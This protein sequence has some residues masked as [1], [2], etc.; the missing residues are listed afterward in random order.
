MPEQASQNAL[1]VTTSPYQSPF[2]TAIY[3]F[4]LGG[5]NMKDQADQIPVG[6]FALHTNLTHTMDRGVTTRY[7]LS[8]YATGGTKHHSV[9]RLSD[10]LNSTYTR[11][12]G[13][14]QDLR[15]GQSGAVAII[16]SG[17]SGDPLVLLPHRPPLSGAPWMFV[18]DRSR[19][20]KVRVDGLD[21]PIG[22]PAPATIPTLSL[23]TEYFTQ[24]ARVDHVDST[25]ATAWTPNAGYTFP[26]PLVGNAP[27]HTGV[28]TMV[29]DS[30]FLLTP[31]LAATT[32]ND[33]WYS[34]WGL[35][36]SL[37]LTKLKANGTGTVK[38]ADDE[39]AMHLKLQLVNPE[40]VKEVRLYLVCSNN[41]SPQVLPGVNSGGLNSDFYMKAFTPDA[42]AR[43]VNPYQST[44][45]ATLDAELTLA[46]QVALTDLTNAQQR[47]GFNA[48]ATRRRATQAFVTAEYLRSISLRAAAI[49]NEV[50]EFGSVGYS[51]RRSDFRRFGTTV[52]CDWSTI[53]G[54]I[55]FYAV[56]DHVT[57]VTSITLQDWK[58]TGG[59]GPDTMDPGVNSYDYRYTNYD[60]R[61]GA[62]GNPTPEQTD[63]TLFID[64]IRRGIIVQ[65]A[66]YGDAAIRQRIY[67]RGGTNV[68]DWFFVDVNASDGGAYLDLFS[69]DEVSTAGTVNLDHFEAVPT[70]DVNGN[71]ILAQP[72]PVLFGPAQGLLFGLGD[73]NRPGH[74]YWCIPGEPDHWPAESNLE[75]CSPSE[76]LMAGLMY[77]PQPLAFSRERLYA[78]YPNLTGDIEVTAT[79]T[80]CR[81]GIVS[82]WAWAI[83]L[84]GIYGVAKDGIFNTGGGVEEIISQ[85]IQPL[86]RGTVWNGYQP[87]DFTVPTA[88]RLSC[89]LDQLFLHY[90]GT[91][92]NRY[93]IVYAILFKFWTPWSFG[94]QTT[95]LLPDEDTP[96]ALL[97]V[98]GLTTGKSYLY[99]PAAFSDD[100]VAIPCT[101]RTKDWDMDRPRE[102]KLLGDL[103]VDADPQGATLSL[104][105]LL[106]N[107]TVVNGTQT[108]DAGT[109]RLRYTFD[110]F[111]TVPQRARNVATTIAWSSSTGRPVLYFMGIS[112][113]PE[114]DQTLNR[115]TQWDD[116]GHPDEFY[117]TGV[118]FDCD[119]GGIDR[120][121]IIEKDYNGLV[122]TVATLLVNANGRHK[123]SFS[124]LGQQAR[125]VRI[126]PT[127]DCIA[128]ILYQADWIKVNEPPRIAAWDIHYEAD[129]DQYYTGLDLY[130]DTGG[131]EKRVK[132]TVDGATLTNPYTGLQYWSVT[133]V[134]RQWIHLTFLAGRGH[135]FHFEATDLNIGLLYR[136]KWFLVPEPSEQSNWNQGYSVHGTLADKWFKAFL[137]EVDTFGQN[138]TVTVDL[139]GT[140]VE[141]F[142]VNTTGRQVVHHALA[143][144]RLGRVLRIYPTD[145]NPSRPYTILSI[146]DAEPYS[147]TVW[148][149]QEGDDGVPGYKQWIDANITLVST[150]EVTLTLSIQRSQDGDGA[151]ESHN[152]VIPSTDGAKLDRYI[153]FLPV[154]GV[155][156]KYYFAASAPFRLYREESIVRMQPWGSEQ[157]VITH[158]WGNDDLDPTRGMTNA[159]VAAA[160]DGGS[161]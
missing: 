71:T 59:A 33:G 152:Y 136:H 87:I 79:T 37:D 118:T 28:P 8:S 82:R 110:S 19:M 116:L 9:R 95:Y 119:T 40:F 38:D 150:T 35:A 80:A 26:D 32:P 145:G 107:E 126:R 67:R 56:L 92:G 122:T 65:P 43:V 106:N 135:V 57:G 51:L 69:D 76:E 42:F 158:P 121:I 11:L 113:I 20:R 120:T 160:R 133:T 50:R 151:V 48:A 52:G 159:D 89:Y 36:K 4:G 84:G 97:F 63:L 49:S 14:D 15:I 130:C 146:F 17:Y 22:L 115:M 129:G 21:V 7:G 132:V 123:L 54:L 85:D 12:W 44:D 139:D 99:D 100:G 161:A 88:I 157:D 53:T 105:T 109:G 29:D 154:K 58:L 2:Q 91:D 30:V 64:A 127:D 46:G 124:W 73:P 45:E 81:R 68:D 55:L 149:T 31:G 138:K 108:F 78:I 137:F 16:D 140:V 101:I 155:K 93:T 13:T 94:K 104:T 148:Q 27:V 144:Q 98:G 60:P 62:E 86:F 23:D 6:Q 143:T 142:S 103:I 102:D 96:V 125:K 47:T 112:Y 3:P 61:T 75:V 34:F 77:G 83:G 90:Q 25:N 114:P 111:G 117:L 5:V 10:P 1:P 70:Q 134:G 156:R 72:V 131:L 18:A 147:L 153:S 39:D 24:I 66:A 41:F 74:L 128:W 141:T